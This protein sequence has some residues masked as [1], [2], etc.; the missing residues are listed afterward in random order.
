MEKD[1]YGIVFAQRYIRLETIIHK[2][3]VEL[4]EEDLNLIRRVIFD[5]MTHAGDP[6]PEEIV[7]HIR[8]QFPALVQDVLQ[9]IMDSGMILPHEETAEKNNYQ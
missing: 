9:G 3:A 6:M 5:D 8:Q 4:P 2:N 7:Q 1:T